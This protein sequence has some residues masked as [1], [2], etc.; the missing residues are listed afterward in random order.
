MARAATAA[1]RQRRAARG[2]RRPAALLPLGRRRPQARG[3]GALPRARHADHRGLRA[4]RVL[5]HAHPQPPRRVP[6]RLG[7]QAAAVGRAQAR[8][9][10]RDPGQGPE[11]VRRLPQG[12]RGDARGASPTT[13]GSRPATSAASP[14]TASCRSSI[15]RRTSWSPPAARTCRP[16]T[17]SSAS[18]D[19]PLHRARGRLRRRASVPGRRRVAERRRRSTRTSSD[20]RRADAPATAR[21]AL[22]QSAHRRRSTRSSPATRRS[23]GSPIIDSAA[24]R[25]GRAPHRDAQGAP[26]E[27]LRGASGGEFEALYEDV[28][29]QR[30]TAS[31]KR[32][33]NLARGACRPRPPV[34]PTPA[35]VVHRENKWRLLR[36]RPRPAGRPSRTP[37]LL[38]PSLI[39]RHYVLDLD[40]GQELRRVP[41][42]A[43]PRRLHASTGARPG[44]ED[45]YLTLRRHR[46]TA[47]SAARSAGRRGARRARA[48]ARARLLPGRHAGGDPRRG[49]PGAGRSR[50]VALAAPIELRRRR[51]CSSAW[52]RRRASTSSALVDAFG[53]VPWQLHAGGLPVLRPTLPLA[54][55]G[56]R[57]STAPGRRRVP[58]RLP[59]A[60]DLG[61]RQ[62]VDF[63]GECYRRYIEELYRERRAGRA[64]RSRCAAGRRGS[65]PS[66]ARR[67]R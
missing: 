40:A 39:N 4:H 51:A 27:G 1:K 59:R 21:T 50:C 19:D 41:R 26:Q 29:A 32:L 8:R 20:G 43:G 65:R 10:R 13:A 36:Y 42:R 5:A 22:V 55:A 56:R 3:E 9:G 24:H 16:P 15:A 60:R 62:R 18:R 67:W 30:S 54:K 46:A 48:G 2:H 49:A 34:G 12:P 11:R 6:L 47:T 14:T 23:S 52:T 33:L 38:V 63:P 28:R 37:V 31:A 66:R 17:S 25:R 44:D 58:R 45:R 61:Q 7:R 53:N 35:D 57:C 64:A